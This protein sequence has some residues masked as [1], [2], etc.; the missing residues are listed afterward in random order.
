MG[1]S[2]KNRSMEQFESATKKIMD[3]QKIP[4]F[5]VGVRKDGK[6]IYDQGFGYRDAEEQYTVNS[7][8]I[9][10]IASMTKSFTCVAIM[11]LQEE[12]KLNVHDQ[13]IT[14]LPEFKTPNAET[15]KEITI[16]HLMTH[17]AGVPP[18]PSGLL[19]MKLSLEKDPSAK[20]YPGLDLLS[21][22]GNPITTYDELI[23][24]L[25]NLEYK[26]LGKPG[27]VFSYSNDSYSLL[28]AIINRVSGE[29]YSQYIID[30]ITKPANMLDTFFNIEQ[31]KQRGNVTTLFARK[32]EEV[33][34]A[35]I[36]WESSIGGA[37]GLKSTV[38]DILKYTEIFVN[39]GMINGTRILR[40][41]SVETM[42]HPHAQIVPGTHY[43]YGFM[44]DPDY[45]G[46][47][48]IEHG[49]SSKGVSSLM[50]MIPEKGLASTALTNLAGV[51]TDQ[52]LLGALNTLQ[53]KE[54]DAS[55]ESYDHQEMPIEKLTDYI[56]TYTS[57]EGATLTVAIEENK[58]V[59]SSKG[60]RQ[61][62]RSI[63]ED[64]FVGIVKSSEEKIQ[65]TRDNKGRVER[66][67]YHYR[68][69]FKDKK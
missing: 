26:M 54:F 22:K 16:H 63:G 68:Q 18:L 20:D 6:R 10:G 50:C 12:G 69:V 13:V 3:E 7:D 25:S 32:G 1:K 39:E 49:G 66:I 34:P 23:E 60:V 31:V 19:T 43:G 47:T 55:H 41:E 61:P 11:Q 33:Y 45:Y 62:L 65:F 53:N 15:T 17:T 9:F 37:G 24:F 2:F 52:I 59:L 8:T 36:W 51:S 35:P 42:I 64:L 4:G 28:G 67:S 58:L 57:E 21:A 27:E 48:L 44:I 40:K 30:H 29:P 5:V 38:N 14:Y 56:G 46:A